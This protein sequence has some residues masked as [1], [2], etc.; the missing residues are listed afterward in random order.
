[1]MNTTRTLLVVAVVL[2]A[3]LA[4]AGP[5]AAQPDP[6]AEFYGSAAVD[7]EPAPEGTTVQAVLDGEVVDETAVDGDGQYGGADP[8]AERLT[9]Q[10]AAGG[11]SETIEFRLA[12]GATADQTAS[13]TPGE[14]V[15]VDLTFPSLGDDPDGGDGS[16]GSD[17]GDGSDGSDGGDSGDGSDGGSSGAPSGGGGGGG[18][19]G[20][21]GASTPDGPSVDVISVDDG[22]TLRV[23]D[24]PGNDPVD[25]DVAG[26]ASG[27]GVSIRSMTV[28]HRLEPDDYRIEVTNV[29]ERPT[30]GASALDDAEAVGYFDVE[31]IGT[32]R[33]RS[34]TLEFTVDPASLPGNAS[35]DDVAL[36][37]YADGWER[38]DTEAVSTDGDRYEFAAQVDAFSPFAVGV[39]TAD[40]AVTEAGVTAEEVAAGDVVEVTATVTNDGAA[41]GTATVTLLV[42]GEERTDQRVTVPGGESIEVLFSTPVDEAGEY[43]FAVDDADAGSVSVV[44]GDATADTESSGAENGDAES[45]GDTPLEEQAPGFGPVVALLALLGAALLARRH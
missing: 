20:Q 21:V 39:A 24:V 31:P 16:D 8:L 10:C 23:E 9:V 41:D 27:A 15:E 17:G 5:A 18:G 32:D 36:Y 26:A 22:A 25:V 12:S 19:G 11:G 2:L 42:D 7:G 38:L 43:S 14:A 6:P 4:A 33:I 3:P 28:D 29:A 45:G 40:V 35:A 30:G 44:E 1:M 13:C 34:A 37:H